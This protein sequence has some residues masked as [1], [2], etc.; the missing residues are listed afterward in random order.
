MF[1]AR[2]FPKFECRFVSGVTRS[3]LDKKYVERYSTRVI[4]ASVMGPDGPFE[5]RRN[6]P[7]VYTVRK[8]IMSKTVDAQFYGPLAHGILISERDGTIMTDRRPAQPGRTYRFIMCSSTGGSLPEKASEMY[9]AAGDVFVVADLGLRLFARENY[10]AAV[11][12]AHV[13]GKEVYGLTDDPFEGI[14]V[15]VMGEAEEKRVAVRPLERKTLAPPSMETAGAKTANDNHVRIVPPPNDNET[16]GD[17]TM[18]DSDILLTPGVYQGCASDD[19]RYLVKRREP[20]GLYMAIRFFRSSRG[21]FKTRAPAP[22]APQPSSARS[23]LAW[24]WLPSLAPETAR[25]KESS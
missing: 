5:K 17:K 1:L 14:P 15:V 11:M 3:I 22:W 25:P 23:S 10:A 9:H 8:S 24:G 6:R 18:V 12:I 20:C 2:S 7:T 16:A 4:P 21:S 13:P 19:E